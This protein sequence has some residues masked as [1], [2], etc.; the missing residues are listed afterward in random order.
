M[1]ESTNSKWEKTS[2]ERRLVISLWSHEYLPSSQPKSLCPQRETQ[3]ET[4]TSSSSLDQWVE[5]LWEHHDWYL[6]PLAPKGNH[7]VNDCNSSCPQRLWQ[8]LWELHHHHHWSTHLKG[9]P[10][11]IALKLNGKCTHKRH[12][13]TNSCTNPKHALEKHHLRDTAQDLQWEMH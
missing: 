11:V 4:H 1:K 2:N 6:I 13:S 9:N 7:T 8:H 5:H 12:G 3:W 10:T